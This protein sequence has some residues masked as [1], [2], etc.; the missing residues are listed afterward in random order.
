MSLGAIDPAGRNAALF[1]F[2]LG[3]AGLILGIGANLSLFIYV[4][5]AVMEM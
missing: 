1:G 3:L 5:R 4:V 2:R